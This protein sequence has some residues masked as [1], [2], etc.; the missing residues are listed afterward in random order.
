MCPISPEKDVSVS[1]RSLSKPVIM[2]IVAGMLLCLLLMALHYVRGISELLYAEAQDNISEIAAQGAGRL[3]DSIRIRLGEARETAVRLSYALQGE[4]SSGTMEDHF[5]QFMGRKSENACL[6]YSIAFP[7]G[8]ALREDGYHFD[9]TSE[10]GFQRALRGLANVSEPFHSV[11][12][13]LRVLAIYSPVVLSGHVEGVLRV[14]ASVDCFYE[15]FGSPFYRG[16][17]FSYILSSTGRLVSVSMDKRNPLI[18]SNIF[19]LLEEDSTAEHRVEQLREAM[20]QGKEGVTTLKMGRS[21]DK[22]LIS[23]EPLA[24]E[25]DWYFVALVPEEVILENSREIML[26]SSLLCGVI[27]LVVLAS[28]LLFARERSRNQAH[29]MKLA[30]VDEL[31][32]L[33][34]RN[35]LI[36]AEKSFPHKPQSE[37]FALAVFDIDN[38]KLINENFGYK[39][40]DRILQNTASA[41]AE[42][43]DP[44]FELGVRTGGDLFVLVL[45]YPGSDKD[46]LERRM[47]DFIKKISVLVEQSAAFVG[48]LKFS[49]G[50]CAVTP[51]YVEGSKCYDYADIARKYVKKQNDLSVSFFEDSMLAV[52]RQE[53]EIESSMEKALTDGEFQIYLQPKIDLH[54]ETLNGAEAL[55]RWIRPDRGSV[56]PNDFIPLFERNGFVV[57]LDYYVMEEVCRLKHHWREQG[58]PDRVISVNMSQYHLV[59]KDFVS[60]LEAIARKYDISPETLEI[61]ITESAFYSDSDAYEVMEDIKVAGFKLSMDDFGAGYSTLNM[62]RRMPVDV[63]KID[64]QFLDESEAS[65]RTRAIISSIIHMAYTIGA[66]VICEGVETLRQV[67]FLK[68]I[69]C[70][71][72]QGHFFSRPLPVSE[73]ERKYC[74]ALP[75]LKTKSA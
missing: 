20:G 34:N 29:I 12:S 65:E 42:E 37:T 49:C 47:Y 73:F 11:Y 26:R 48:S 15:A 31:T 39:T 35:R 62:L 69:G 18:F 7:D 66:D 54:S 28:V 3:T 68:S 53:K 57:K 52:M 16:H 6:R 5:L 13:G 70:N 50:I 4:E 14:A 10:L 71:L 64:K 38:F 61:E 24:A 1:E 33:P 51:E 21:G 23:Y 72:V 41:I 67:E 22:Y 17:G 60:T 63:L 43:I 58:R 46:A 9:V 2:A 19:D 56:P 25:L 8:K 44:A 40:G 55:V 27:I 30:F 75:E 59:Q 32:G 74:E 45:R 36:E